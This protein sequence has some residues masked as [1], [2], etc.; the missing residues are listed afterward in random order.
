ML[1]DYVAGRTEDGVEGPAA[2]EIVETYFI[3]DRALFTGESAT[4]QRVFAKDMTFRQ[5]SGG[6]YFA[7]WHGKIGHRFFRMHF[8][9]PLEK[10]RKKLEI[11]YL[12]PKI[13]K[14]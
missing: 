5:A 1:N 12:G 10:H 8:E 7:H 6:D 3:G 13:T 14:G 11:F 9:W 2:R 4:N